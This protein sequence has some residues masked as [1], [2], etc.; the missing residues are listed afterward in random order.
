MKTHC[1]KGRP[2]KPYFSFFLASIPRNPYHDI[3]SL[4]VNGVTPGVVSQSCVRVSVVLRRTVCDDI[5]WRLDNPSGSHHQSK[6]IVTN[7]DGSKTANHGL[8]WIKS[9][10]FWQTT[11][12]IATSST[13]QVNNQILITSSD[14]SAQVA[15]TSVKG[16][17]NS[18]RRD[19]SYLPIYFSSNNK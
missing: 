16:I 2:N 3:I 6:W 5:D 9:R 13:N 8:Q 17:T 4:T 10:R 19:Y 18:P 12:H 14:D 11:N 1:I 15:E 7:F